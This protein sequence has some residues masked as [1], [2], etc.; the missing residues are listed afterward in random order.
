MKKLSSALLFS[1]LLFGI[2]ACVPAGPSGKDGADGSADSAD[3]SDPST[4]DP[5]PE[6]IHYG[7]AV[8]SGETYTDERGTYERLTLPEDHAINQYD[9]ATP[10]EAADQFDWTDEELTEGKRLAAEYLITQYMDSTILDTESQQE[11][12]KWQTQEAAHYLDRPSFG[13]DEEMFLTILANFERPGTDMSNPL[14]VRDGKPRYE[15]ITVDI[16]DS[17]AG[18]NTQ[19]NDDLL[20]FTYEVLYTQRSSNEALVD[21][22]N[23]HNQTATVSRLVNDST[24]NLLYGITEVSIYVGKDDTGAW[25]VFGVSGSWNASIDDIYSK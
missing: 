19:T 25:K 14:L 12:T 20:A 18:V 3:S 7:D 21:F 8:G 16:I 24:I 9:P 22:F 11:I 13:S 23:H 17:F 2:T 4:P 5:T 6:V 1:A 15:S 10:L